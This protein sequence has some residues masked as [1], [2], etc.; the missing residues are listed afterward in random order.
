MAKHLHR[1]DLAV[2]AVE[3]GASPQAAVDQLR[4]PV[5][6]QRRAEFLAQVQIWSTAR[7]RRAGELV[8]EAEISLKTAGMPAVAVTQRAL[9]R[10]ANAARNA[11]RR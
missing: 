4:P 1:L 9:M 8:T 6:F 7:L 11:A 10:L 2:A 3:G 5:F